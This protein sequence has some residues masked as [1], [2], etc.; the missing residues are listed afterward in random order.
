MTISLGVVWRAPNPQTDQNPVLPAFQKFCSCFYP[1]NELKILKFE[2]MALHVDRGHSQ[3]PFSVT[4]REIR[5]KP[6]PEGIT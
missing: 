4:L 5:V 1:R 6:N 2:L 3:P